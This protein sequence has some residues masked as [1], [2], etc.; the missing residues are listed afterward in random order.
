M[1]A[2]YTFLLG[3]FCVGVT[4]AQSDIASVEYFFDSDPGIGNGI[5]VDIDPD[6][7]LL[8]QN[9]SI[10]TTGLPQGTHRLFMRV[11]NTNGSTSMY[12]Y[13]T[14]RI[15]DVP[16]INTADIVEAEYFFNTDPG[17]GNGN[18]RTV[19][20]ATNMNRNF[21]V[22]TGGLP[23]GTHRLFFR[24]KNSDNEWSMYTY[25]TF[26]KT[27]VPDTNLADIVEAEYYFNTDPGLGNGTNI[28][29]ADVSSLDENFSIPTSS[30]PIG[31]HR[32]FLRVKNS[33]NRWSLYAN[34]T[35]RVTESPDTN[36]ADIVE[37]E[38]Y[39]N[40]DPGLGNGTIIDVTDVATLDENFNIPVSSLPI[41]THRLF[42]RV[43]N[44]NDTWSLYDH[45]T[46]R[47]SDI[48]DTNLADIV[49][50]EYYF[51]TDPGLGNGTNIDVADVASLDENFIIPTSSLPI[52]THRM[53]MR[54]KNYDNKWSM[55]NHKTFR[56]SDITETNNASIM[57]A[58][59][60]IDVDPG[61]GN[62]SALTVSGDIIDE[63]LIIPTFGSM[64]QGDHFLHIRVQNADGT[65][66]LYDRQLFEIDGTLGIQTENLLEI[67]IYPIP[68]SDY[69]N[70]KTPNHVQIKSM[71]LIDM[72]GKVVMQLQNQFEKVNISNLQ[73]GVYLLQITTNNGSLSKRIIKN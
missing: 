34:K 4:L 71:R 72:N 57:A 49:E 8:D 27:D 52:G 63:N 62:A 56:V 36:L 31:T 55:Y 2:L 40:I 19:S 66:S 73:Q 6:V 61:I 35:F 18:L 51:N 48:P 53:F 25:K 70:I 65:W 12:N 41:G 58:E 59:Y 60:F 30:L 13:K 47:V 26:R 21:N 38:Y 39:F 29:V 69:V 33:D 32:M 20:N 37:A 28:D 22:L 42:L 45:K 44:N 68:T 3:C 43:K 46:F 14:F 7:E 23:V 16:E 54:V 11:V 5:S 9:F 67:N 50:A 1:K 10:S 17:F 15:Y 24:V 64:A